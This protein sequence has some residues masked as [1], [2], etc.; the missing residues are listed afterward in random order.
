M[1]EIALHTNTLQ[2]G[3][4]YMTYISKC[5]PKWAILGGVYFLTFIY[6]VYSLYLW[7]IS[8][9]QILPGGYFN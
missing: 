4:A 2:C 5:K 9:D 3:A 8:Y 7:N 6:S 1:H